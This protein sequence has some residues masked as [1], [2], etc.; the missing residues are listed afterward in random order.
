M[1]VFCCSLFACA[2]SLVDSIAAA[3]INIA[4]LVNRTPQQQQQQQPPHAGLSG[5]AVLAGALLRLWHSTEQ[6]EHSSKQ[7][8]ST[9]FAAGSLAVAVMKAYPA[10]SSNSSS[11]NAPCAPTSSS[12]APVP[13]HMTNADQAVQPAPD[14]VAQAAALLQLRELQQAALNTAHYVSLAVT[15]LYVNA[16]SIDSQSLPSQLRVLEWAADFRHA[17]CDSL[18]DLFLLLHIAW[19]TQKQ[20]QHHQQQQRAQLNS[21]TSST[22]SRQ[23]QQTQQPVPCWHVQF[24]T[25]AGAAVWDASG[26]ISSPWQGAANLRE[27]TYN[28]FGA[29]TFVATSFEQRQS[30]SSSSTSSS[31]SN[32]SRWQQQRPER[33]LPCS[34]A[35]LLLLE[36]LL[37]EAAHDEADDEIMKECSMRISL[38]LQFMLLR[39]MLA[40]QASGASERDAAAQA[41]SASETAARPLLPYVLHLL[42]PRM[43]ALATS[44]RSS[45]S[46]WCCWC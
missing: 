23:Q 6:L 32:G 33:K 42:G 10:S 28:V 15:A 27:A 43:L 4:V 12:N 26:G 22:S 5:A 9:V 46:W 45:S 24:L 35:L 20:Q 39:A 16:Q 19:L 11:S 34:D 14:G 7:A 1:H 13:A 17:S 38:I 18:A 25:A 44:S 37:L 30:D 29:L 31:S 36:V 40:A 8:D 2:H 21:S 41:H 3:C